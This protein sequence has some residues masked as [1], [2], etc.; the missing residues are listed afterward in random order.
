MKK[1]LAVAL[2]MLG[3]GLTGMIFAFDK[4]DIKKLEGEP[5]VEEKTVDSEQ[6]RSIMTKTDLMNIE[7]TRGRGDDIYI[8]LE[9]KAG[10][11][12][13]DRIN[14][15]AEPKGDTLYI[16]GK[17]KRQVFA[18]GWSPLRLTLIVELPERLWDSIELDSDTG[19]IVLDQLH[20]RKI[21]VDSDIGNIKAMQYETEQFQ[22]ESDAGNV[23]LLDGTGEVKGKSDIGNI[24]M[25]ADQVGGDIAL[26]SDTGSIT[27]NVDQEPESAAIRIKKEL[28]SS[29]IEWD[30]FHSDY[31][32]KYNES[33][34]I[35]NGDIQIDITT[36]IGNVKLGYR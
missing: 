24:R 10:K 21:T 4:D 30:G 20:A 18:F 34:M 36:E 3:V 27:V 14:L 28:G 19:N 6:I 35:G 33:G 8:R 7:M 15:V 22:F 32:K 31:N 23:Y 13:L 16:E 25:E 5:F 1:L 9:G 11:N 26:K 2:I 29:K 17:L 12:Q